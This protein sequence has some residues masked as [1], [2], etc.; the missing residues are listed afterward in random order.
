MRVELEDKAKRT[1]E[2][3]LAKGNSAEVKVCKDRVVVWELSSKKRIESPVTP[4]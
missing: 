4:R 1:I 3:I 2:E